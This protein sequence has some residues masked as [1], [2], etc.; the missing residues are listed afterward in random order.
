MKDFLPLL[1][2]ESVQLGILEPRFF[3]YQRS[4]GLITGLYHGPGESLIIDPA[5]PRGSIGAFAQRNH[6]RMLVARLKKLL[7]I[8]ESSGSILP[9]SARIFCNSSLPEKQFALTSELGIRGKNSLVIIP[10]VGSC[11]V[12]G[13]ILFSPSDMKEAVFSSVNRVEDSFSAFQKDFPLC[14]GCRACIETCPTGALVQEGFVDRGRCLQ[15]H[16]SHLLPMPSPIRTAWGALFYGCDRCQS[17]CPHN[18]HTTH[19]PPPLVPNERGVLGPGVELQKV[20]QTPEEAL[21]KGLFQGSVLDVGWIS[22]L[23]LKRSALL[24]CAYQSAATILPEVLEF[25]THPEPLLRE[26]A[27]YA[28]EKLEAS[29]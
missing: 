29:G 26:A 18:L 11:V 5:F 6:Y 7:H 22:P 16:A 13:G 21:R 27:L 24:A 12:L 9:G 15:N 3:R 8:L 14:S 1:I 17:V 2:E 25:T 10:G 20:L 23:T 4:I 19:T 28:K